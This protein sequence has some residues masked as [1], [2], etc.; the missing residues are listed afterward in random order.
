[1]ETPLPI[2]SQASFFAGS[3]NVA[4]HS[5]PGTELIWLLRG[6]CEIVTSRETF[7]LVP[8]AMMVIAPECE[9]NQICHG[10][11]ENLF[12]V[13]VADPMF[14]D[15]RTRTIEVGGDP[16]G[17]RLMQNI[18]DLSMARHYD[19]CDG[20]IYSLLKHLK[21]RESELE[22]HGS[23]HPGLLRALE[24][25]K[26]DFQDPLDIQEIARHAGISSSYLRSLFIAHF[27]QSP[28]QYLQSIR[29]AHARELL[30]NQY[31][32]VAEVATR[33]GYDD[34]NYFSRLFRK[35]HHQSP[36]EYREIVRSRDPNREIRL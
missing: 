35:I 27:G 8:G 19:L 31:W 11:V 5:H 1:M 12:A 32:N 2:F 13:F 18:V 7:H 16:W 21:T 26:A 23:C 20:I 14:F 29:M 30:L 25:I 22:T 33:C 9:H 4:F 10:E 24:K 17:G 6:D 34:A 28:M 36:G 3:R 15:S